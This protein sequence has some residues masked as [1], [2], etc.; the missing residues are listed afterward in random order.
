VF[1]EAERAAF[2]SWAEQFVAVGKERADHQV[3]A[4]GLAD[5]TFHG[6]RSNWQRYGNSAT[7]ARAL[8]VAAAAVAGERQLRSTLE[9]N[10]SHRTAGGRDNG[11]SAL[12]DGEIID[13]TGGET[14]EGRGRNDIGYGL[15]GSDALLVVANVAKHAGFRRNLFAF[16]TP[17]GDSVLSPFAYYG[18]Y[19]SDQRPWP[20]SDGSF[21]HKEGTAAT[22]RAA[23]EVAFKNA[24]PALK[25]RLGRVVN[26]GGPG[27]RGANYDPYIWVYAALGAGS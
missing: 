23:S 17:S 10:W 18:R 22:Y 9:W 7:F 8:A 20:S 24:G 13:G 4:P 6:E 27:Q 2:K 26:F 14:F 21:S 16:R 25:A 12:I 19:L 15:L 3:D 1:T 5:Q 11:W